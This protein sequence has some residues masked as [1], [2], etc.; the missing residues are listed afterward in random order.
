[1]HILQVSSKHASASQYID[2]KGNLCLKLRLFSN[3]GT[4]CTLQ[5]IAKNSNH[6]IILSD[7]HIAKK[8][9]SK[10]CNYHDYFFT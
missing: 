2:N 5:Q 9:H 3:A 6:S 8:Q 10:V 7:K 1:M 4:Q